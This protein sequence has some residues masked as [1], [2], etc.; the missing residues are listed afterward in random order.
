MGISIFIWVI[1]AVI[2]IIAIYHNKKAKEEA[3]AERER[4]H[5]EWETWQADIKK[6]DKALRAEIRKTK[7]KAEKAMINDMV[8]KTSA[9]SAAW[10][11]AMEQAQGEFRE[12]GIADLSVQN[13][14]LVKRTDEIYASGA[15][16]EIE[17]ES[18]QSY[19]KREKEMSIKSLPGETYGGYAF[20]LAQMVTVEGL[21]EESLVA[22]GKT[23][24]KALA[25]RK[26]KYQIKQ[27]LF[28]AVIN[29]D[30]EFFVE[31]AFADCF[32]LEKPIISAFYH[33]FEY[34]SEA[35]AH[36]I[37]N[38][39]KYLNHYPELKDEILK[40]ALWIARGCPE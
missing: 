19:L 23:M 1:I 8:A 28:M 31:L 7:R 21:P 25:A 3:Q 16:A 10:N 11:K 37:I 40:D 20:S 4:K 13:P 36:E 26:K 34:K 15:F 38:K 30:T 39:S 18:Y 33:E 17:K 2:S 35:E 32:F 5:R 14:D 6:Q 27:D 12:K 22:I 24:V 29:W 9:K